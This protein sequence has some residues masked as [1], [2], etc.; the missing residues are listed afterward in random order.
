MLN[1]SDATRIKPK[2]VI[3]YYLIDFTYF[4]HIIYHHIFLKQAVW[5]YVSNYIF[6]FYN[7][8]KITFHLLEYIIYITSYQK[9]FV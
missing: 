6:F 8:N 2:C 4:L 1:L 9:K 7:L 5:S 3:L